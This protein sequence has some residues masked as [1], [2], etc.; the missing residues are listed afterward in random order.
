MTM[1]FRVSAN[2][3]YFMDYGFGYGFRKLVSILVIKNRISFFA[4]KTSKIIKL[5]E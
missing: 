3:L 5:K 1:K 4:E 2:K